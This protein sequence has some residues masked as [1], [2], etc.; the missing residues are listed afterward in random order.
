MRSIHPLPGGDPHP[1]VL[2]L[3]TY[4]P[5][6]K[7]MGMWASSSLDVTHKIKKRHGEESYLEGQGKRPNLMGII[8]PP[9]MRLYH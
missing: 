7:R 9:L 3:W 1:E 8:T 4:E 2:T 6:S 5:P